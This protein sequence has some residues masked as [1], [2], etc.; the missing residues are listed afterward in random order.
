MTDVSLFTDDEFMKQ[1]QKQYISKT[2]DQITGRTGI[3][4][5]T[6]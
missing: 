3:E 4:L 2:L 6:T 1:S 5:R